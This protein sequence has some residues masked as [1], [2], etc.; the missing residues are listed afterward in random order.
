MNPFHNKL[1]STFS[2]AS[3]K[4]EYEMPFSN[5]VNSHI[6]RSEYQTTQPFLIPFL[7]LPYEIKLLIYEA[8]DVPTLFNL[9][10]TAPMLRKDA[11]RAFWSHQSPWYVTDNTW[12]NFEYGYPGSKPHCPEFACRVEQVEVHFE[13]R[14]GMNFYHD[15]SGPTGR[16]GAGQ[17]RVINDKRRL[18]SSEQQ[19]KKF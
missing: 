11:E 16:A 14:L 12:L 3:Y 19:T 5:Y 6:A 17:W 13:G 4:H 9:M 7:G 18:L 10:R 8:S 15:P 2:N 1:L